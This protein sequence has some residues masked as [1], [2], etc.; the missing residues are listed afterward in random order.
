MT[1]STGV[2]P[3]YLGKPY[4]TT[5]DMIGEVTGIAR[6]DMCIFGDRLYTDIAIGKRHGVTSVLVLSGETKIADVER[7]DAADRPDYV[8]ADLGAVME[9]K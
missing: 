2:A 8:C 6:E 9:D 1:A 5:I 7:A 3:V 4:T